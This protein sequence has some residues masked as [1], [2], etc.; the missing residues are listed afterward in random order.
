[1]SGTFF[2]HAN[3][4]KVRMQNLFRKKFPLQCNLNQSLLI[5]G[6]RIQISRYFLQENVKDL[7]GYT[8]VSYLFIDE[9]DHFE[10]S[11]NSELLHAIT[12]YEEKSKLY[13]DNV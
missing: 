4:L 12:R 2:H 13:N 11:V 6:L 1:M 3:E 5:Y 8:D 10:P 7:R 9:A